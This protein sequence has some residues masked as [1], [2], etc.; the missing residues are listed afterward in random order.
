MIAAGLPLTWL[1]EQKADFKNYLLQHREVSFAFR[2]TDYRIKIV[3]AEVY[4]QGFAAVAERLRDFGGV[5][6][7]CNIGNGTMNILRIVNRKPDPR[8]MFT[9][10]YGTHKCAFLIWEQMRKRHHAS[11]DDSV[12]TEVL[13]K[14]T[15]DID[16]AYLEA[17]VGAAGMFRRLR[18]HEYDLKLMKLY[19]VDG[20]D[21]L[22]RNFADCDSGRVFI[23]EDICATA[24]GYEYMALMTLK[25]NGGAV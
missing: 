12:M 15:A 8:R 16:K 11:L 19:V 4:P 7:L 6:M 10:K 2:N 20:G 25:R 21:C 9:E 5:N 24:K 13:R 18:E 23:N 17:V 1:S 3:G 22:I 14:G